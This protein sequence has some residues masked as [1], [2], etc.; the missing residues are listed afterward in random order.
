MKKPNFF[1]IGAPKSGTTALASYL[2][3][4]PN[5]FLSDPKEP[6]H[7]NSDLNHGSFKNRD[8]YLSLFEDTQACHS[9]IGEASVWYLYSAEAVNNILNDIPDARFIVMLR[10]PVDMAPS[11]HEQMVFTGY[12]TERDFETAWALQERRRNGDSVPLWCDEPRLLL[13]KEACSIGEQYERVASV[14]PEASLLPIIF[15][16]FKADPRSVWLTV[17]K[18]LGVQDDGRTDF[19]VVNAAKIRRSVFLKRLADVY[20]KVRLFFGF[21]GFGSGLFSK[22]DAWNTDTRVRPPLDPDFLARLKCVFHEDVML[23]E[24]CLERNLEQWK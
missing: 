18:F 5:V 13:Y 19:P 4:H 8:K 16:D 17:L 15:D 22:V 24:R 14:V 10:N 11:L 9:A 3:L 1:I 23:L 7:Y 20:C 12:E 6:H 21:R 2:A